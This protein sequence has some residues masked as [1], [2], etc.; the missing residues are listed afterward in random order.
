MHN[1]IKNVFVCCCYSE[2]IIA[3]VQSTPSFFAKNEEKK[4]ENEHSSD[5]P[6]ISE[7][8][9]SPNMNR[10]QSVFV[11]KVSFIDEDDQKEEATNKKKKKKSRYLSF[12]G[13]KKSKK[14]DKTP[15]ISTTNSAGSA[16]ISTKLSMSV[17]ES[18]S[19][20]EEVE[21]G[22]TLQLKDIPS[23]KSD[24]LPTY[25]KRSKSVFAKL[26]RVSIAEDN[27]EDAKR[28]KKELDQIK[29]IRKQ[30]LKQ[31]NVLKKEN[32][33]MEEKFAKIQKEKK[34]QNA[35]IKRMEELNKTKNEIMG[36]MQKE[37][38]VHVSC[39]ILC[40]FCVCSWRKQKRKTVIW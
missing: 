39:D 22:K 2:R 31:M 36:K 34:S 33:A 28:L 10:S 20:S 38:C 21:D 32:K 18:L 37:V 23:D 7:S 15:M 29:K 11:K 40:D 17:T 4:E 27:N 16:S 24:T 3:K 8:H 25:T 1:K 19:Q 26:K 9:S 5:Q 30:E 13:R 14:F 12:F 35:Q 6:S